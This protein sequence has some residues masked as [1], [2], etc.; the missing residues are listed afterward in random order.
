MS[1]KSPNVHPP[2][3]TAQSRG[4]GARNERHLFQCEICTNDYDNQLRRPFVLLPCGHTVCSVCIDQLENKQCPS[5][6]RA[7]TD[8][9]LNWEVHKCLAPSLEL[10]PLIASTIQASLRLCE[11]QL[12]ESYSF[13]NKRCQEINAKFES[14]FT[15]INQKRFKLNVQFVKNKFLD[16]L[17]VY[18]AYSGHFKRT[19]DRMKSECT[20]MNNEFNSN[21]EREANLFAQ[22]FELVKLNFSCFD[23]ILDKLL[24]QIEDASDNQAFLDEIRRDLT[25]L[26]PLDFVDAYKVSRLES[27]FERQALITRH[28][29]RPIDDRSNFIITNKA[30]LILIVL[31]CLTLAF[32]LSMITTGNA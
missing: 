17:N 4:G 30:A 25:Q 11:L 16:E 10:T 26:R 8:K 23:R 27:E 32:S 1:T 29:S 31:A 7:F 6:R 9:V 18:A 12:A 28:E 5:D 3:S 24:A 13:C 20:Q 14:L 19:V 21:I 15:L 2:T 22:N